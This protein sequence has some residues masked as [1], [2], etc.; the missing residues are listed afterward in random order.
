MLLIAAISIRYT[1]LSRIIASNSPLPSLNPFPSPP[2][3]SKPFS[4]SATPHS[5]Y[6]TLTSCATC[7]S[8]STAAARS[9]RRAIAVS[10][11]TSYL[12][13]INFIVRVG[14]I[15]AVFTV[16]RSIVISN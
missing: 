9:L 8:A 6:H 5:A 14:V 13:T 7:V 12:K 3:T 10:N 4:I 16:F 11:S 15:I 1:L 2:F